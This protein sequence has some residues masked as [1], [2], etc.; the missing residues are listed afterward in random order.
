MWLDLV[1]ALKVNSSP[2]GSILGRF[3]FYESLDL[4]N[5]PANI[6]IRIEKGE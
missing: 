3:V 5:R 2:S 4:E 6:I 1:K